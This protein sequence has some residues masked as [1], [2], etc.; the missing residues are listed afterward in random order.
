MGRGGARRGHPADTATSWRNPCPPP[1]L[2]P[3]SRT[4][5][6]GTARRWPTS[7]AAT[8][9]RSRPTPTSVDPQGLIDLVN[10]AAAFFNSAHHYDQAETLESAAGFLVEA[11]DDDADRPAL[12][13]R[14]TR[15]LADSY[16]MASELADELGDDYDF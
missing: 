16:D 13:K 14:A 11:R 1:R 3:R 6:A 7:P 9:P 5:P 2:R 10:N 4:W 8:T 12:L 15:D